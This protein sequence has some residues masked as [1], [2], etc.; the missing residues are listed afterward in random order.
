[1]EIRL[2]TF[3]DAF[4]FSQ[5]RYPAFIGA[6]ATGKSMCGIMRGM[7]LSE[8][9]PNNL[10]VIFRREFRDLEDSTC[11]DFENYTKLK[12]DSHREV[13]V[14]SS[15]IMFRHLEEL[16]NIQNLNL[17]WFWIEQAEELDS[18]EQ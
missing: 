18:D 6:W 4:I 7:K 10:G 13:R 11:R 2:K 14:G 9:Y 5:S 3:Q 15:V 12:I 8:D 16:N 1:M 17:G